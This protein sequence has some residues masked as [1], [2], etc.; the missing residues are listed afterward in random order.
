M[1][2]VALNYVYFIALNLSPFIY[3]I[4]A[5]TLT[6]NSIFSLSHKV[7]LMLFLPF[8]TIVFMLVSNPYWHMVFEYKNGVYHRGSFQIIMYVVDL[9]YAAFGVVYVLREKKSTTL[10][11]KI[12]LLM[13][14]VVGCA[15]ALIQYI[16][17]EM[18][19]QHLG[20]SVCELIVLINLQK[21]EE[22][23]D[24]QTGAYNRTAF[25]WIFNMNIK[26]KVN[27]QILMINIEDM[28]FLIQTVGVDVE[29]ILIKELADFLPIPLVDMK[30]NNYYFN[31]NYPKSIGK[32]KSFY[33]NF[34]VL[35]KAY[36]YIRSLGAQGL[37]EV[38]E[39]AVLNA[40]YLMRLL[41]KNY[42]LPFNQAC[43]HE[44]VLSGKRQKS[45]G[46]RALDIAKRL[47]DYG[48]HPPTIYFPLI[49]EEA[50]M[51]EPTETE[52][53]E[54]LDQFAH[55]MNE[56]AKEAVENPDKLKNAPFNTPIRRLDEARAVKELDVNWYNKMK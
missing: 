13:F 50:M 26:A 32:V 17:P 44:F 31:Y 5:I 54:T 25:D 53:K 34:L 55:M 40:N 28:N 45:H 37:R 29:K 48:Y 14:F 11:L 21:P 24:S 42:H 9:Y 35:V 41:E 47:L 23:L 38:S 46:V 12:S 15:M 8:L 3:A 18:L 6:K 36:A 30:N 56:I 27:M 39:T 52:N 49:V 10:Q 20:F 33:G 22:Y 19:V 2:L 43:K 1:I 7:K 16:N 4:Y 51:I